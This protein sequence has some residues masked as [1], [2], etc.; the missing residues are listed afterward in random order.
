MLLLSLICLAVG[1]ALGQQ[2]KVLV[3]I[4]SMALAT[5]AVAGIAH[6]GTLWQ[7]LGTAF[8][9]T[10]SLQIGYFAGVSIRYL[11]VYPLG[12]DLISETEV[13]ETELN[14]WAEELRPSETDEEGS[15]DS[16]VA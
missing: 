2:Y 7:I 12:T 3:L 4:P 6:A 13:S 8:L 1:A 14:T 10:S 15:Q 9:A 16:D 5:I 11:M